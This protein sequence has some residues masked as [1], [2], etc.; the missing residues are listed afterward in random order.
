[1]KIFASGDI[2]SMDFNPTKGHE[3]SGRRSAVVLSNK[4]Y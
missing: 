3:Q 1:M 2:I 4:D